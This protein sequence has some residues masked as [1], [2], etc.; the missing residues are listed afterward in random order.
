ML[1][2]LTGDTMTTQAS[3][4]MVERGIEHT[5]IDL[6]KSLGYKTHASQG[7]VVDSQDNMDLPMRLSKQRFIVMRV[8]REFTLA[9]LA[10]TGVGTEAT[11][12]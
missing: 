10:N 3:Q 8:F 9:D 11:S 12:E 5:I 2:I 6:P 4:W 1:I 7:I